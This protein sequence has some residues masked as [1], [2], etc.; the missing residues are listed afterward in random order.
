MTQPKRSSNPAMP[1]VPGHVASVCRS[2]LPP[3]P[4]LWRPVQ[5]DCRALRGRPREEKRKAGLPGGPTCMCVDKVCRPDR[6]AHQAATSAPH[7]AF[8]EGCSAPHSADCG[9]RNRSRTRC[10]PS[11][12][13]NKRRK[14]L[15]PSMG[16]FARLPSWR[17]NR[18]PVSES[19]RGWRPTSQGHGPFA[20]SPAPIIESTAGSLPSAG[21]V[22][23]YLE[24]PTNSIPRI[25]S[26]RA[27]GVPPTTLPPT[28]RH[29]WF[30]GRC[31]GNP[32]TRRR[33]AQ[34]LWGSAVPHG[35]CGT[36]QETPLGRA[37]G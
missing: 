36:Q 26:A 35:G 28:H 16:A 20:R 12:T 21:P 9:R 10:S 29:Y 13:I 11:T 33:A 5:G 17:P 32:P 23:E 6:R 25:G 15:Q 34:R 37:A 24:T 2:G 3:L 18:A 22:L 19:T 27:P 7:L 14:H 8:E 4:W 31:S 1:H 30:L